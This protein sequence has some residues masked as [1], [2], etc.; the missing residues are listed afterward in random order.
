MAPAPCRSFRSL[1]RR[2]WL[3]WEIYA[4][5]SWGRESREHRHQTRRWSLGRGRLRKASSAP[6]AVVRPKDTCC[7]AVALTCS[8]PP[9]GRRM[10]RS[11]CLRN[12]RSRQKEGLT[13]YQSSRCPRR[14]P[15]LWSHCRRLLRCSCRRWLTACCRCCRRW[16]SVRRRLSV[17]WLW[18]R[19]GCRRRCTTS[20]V[21]DWDLV[22]CG[23]RT[24]VCY[25][26][27]SLI[28]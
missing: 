22:P 9:H 16:R 8:L 3:H 6:A 28:N 5:S 14:G 24:T 21:R 19:G 26:D 10:P 13:R 11:A 15:L 20:Q 25:H 23:S 7:S 12:H 27:C 17:F 1:L 18:R 4:R 2:H